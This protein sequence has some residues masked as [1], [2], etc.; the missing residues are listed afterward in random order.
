MQTFS[1]SAKHTPP[2]L[3]CLMRC[4][5]KIMTM[6]L[7]WGEGGADTFRMM[8]SYSGIN[9]VAQQLC[10]ELLIQLTATLISLAFPQLKYRGSISYHAMSCIALKHDVGMYFIMPCNGC[11]TFSFGTSDQRMSSYTTATTTATLKMSTH[12]YHESPTML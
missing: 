11:C 3:M 9:E 8:T 6:I 1:L 2:P 7:K 12:T 4:A 5:C 10:V